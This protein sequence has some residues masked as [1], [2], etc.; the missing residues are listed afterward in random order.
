MCAKKEKRAYYGVGFTSLAGLL[1]DS[2]LSLSAAL[3]S[4]DVR[5]PV[6][7]DGAYISRHIYFREAGMEIKRI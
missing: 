3:V 2:A 5:R 7:T 1:I 6:T 4:A